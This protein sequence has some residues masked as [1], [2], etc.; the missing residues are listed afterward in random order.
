MDGKDRQNQ[1]E[2]IEMTVLISDKGNVK[3]KRDI[4]Y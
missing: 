3:T 2:N 4:S 1:P